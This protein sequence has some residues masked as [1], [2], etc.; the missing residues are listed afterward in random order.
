[1]ELRSSIAFDGDSED[2]FEDFG[3]EADYGNDDEYY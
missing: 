1:M 3:G 2:D